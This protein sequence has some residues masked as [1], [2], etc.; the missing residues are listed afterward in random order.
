MIFRSIAQMINNLE[1]LIKF[2][3]LDEITKQSKTKEMHKQ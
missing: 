2:R 1:S 3:A